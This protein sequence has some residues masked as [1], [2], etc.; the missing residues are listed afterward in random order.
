MRRAREGVTTLSRAQVNR[1]WTPPHNPEELHMRHRHIHLPIILLI[2]LSPLLFWGCS[3]T[4]LTF[5]VRFAV[6]SG[7]KQDNHV[8]FE[9][10]E[11]GR[12]KKVTYTSQGDY[13]VE[14]EIAPG[15]KNAATEHSRF[16]ID[17]APGTTAAMA[18]IVE[19]ERP[20]GEILDNGAIVEGSTRSGYLDKVFDDLR[21][22]AAKAESE[23]NRALEEL[24]KSLDATSAQLNK[25]LQ[26]AV[27][28]LS[29][30]LDAFRQE[31]GRLPDREEVR[32]IEESFRKFAEEF[33]KAQKDVQE[34]IRNEILPRFRAKL[35]HLREQLKKEGRESELEEID[36]QVKEL[37]MV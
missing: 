36:R 20:G 8:Y 11:I 12:V 26:D 7:L 3:D 4:S 13:L 32:E 34:Y 17:H 30:R 37:E 5:Q 33:H 15:F 6:L 21:K 29:L 23:L 16:Y 2:L 35:E 18:V 9:R 22:Q 31:L 27:D 24:K 25:N 10:N 14:V 19:Q 28:E 1:I